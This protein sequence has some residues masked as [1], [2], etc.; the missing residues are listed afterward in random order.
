MADSKVNSGAIP[1]PEDNTFT[2][3]SGAPTVLITGASKGVGA[4]WVC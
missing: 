1:T 3:A 4:A 2:A